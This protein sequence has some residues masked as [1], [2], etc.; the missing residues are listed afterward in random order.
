MFKVEIENQKGEKKIQNCNDEK[1][2]RS[3][4]L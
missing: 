1:K 3:R 4:S 2:P